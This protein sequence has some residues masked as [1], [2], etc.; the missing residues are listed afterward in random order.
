MPEA[1]SPTI[2]AGPLQGWAYA[3]DRS[4][5]TENKAFKTRKAY[6]EALN[7]LGR[8]LAA[9]D[10]PT[11]PGDI[12]PRDI[13]A[14]LIHQLERW[15]PATASVRHRSLQQFFKW[16]L[17]EEE[18]AISPMA[19]VKPPKVP[20]IPVPV[21]ND[22]DLRKLLKACEG[23]GFDER[24]DT[25]LIR[26]MIDSGLRLGE[27]ASLKV[28]DL[29]GESDVALVVGKGRRPRAVPF[30]AATGQALDRY[31]RVRNRHG[32][33]DLE[34]LW[35]G[36]KGRLTDSGIAQL[37]RRRCR[38]AGIVSIHP[39]QLRH[40]FAHNWLADGGQE[41]DLMR[42]AGW[43]SRQMLARYGASAADERARDAHRRLSHGDRL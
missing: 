21:V 6:L 40:S 26:L 7:L 3:W 25:A 18:I 11:E 43:R 1:M 36:V 29:D 4:L 22:G 9:N 20:D 38:Q 41:G 39:H 28:S 33:A 24:R 19:K 34:W 8:F 32:K 10:L 16:L 2:D 31:L 12:R 35:L 37:M 30:G 14:F 27:V 17:D 42:L 5:R 15:R 13:E 23:R